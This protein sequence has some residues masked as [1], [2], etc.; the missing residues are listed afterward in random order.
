MDA[1]LGVSF[2]GYKHLH[3]PQKTHTGDA[4]VHE[5]IVLLSAAKHLIP[6]G[7]NTRRVSRFFAALRM[8]SE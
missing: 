2:D 3:Y 7:R 8:T 6:I 5:G 1:G 4:L